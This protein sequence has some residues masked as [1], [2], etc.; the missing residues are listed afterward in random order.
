MANEDDPC[1][2]CMEPLTT[3]DVHTLD[4][5]GHR[6]HPRCIIG[7]LQRGNLSCPTCRHDLHQQEDAIPGMWIRERAKHIRRTMA[8]RPNIPKPLKTLLTRVKR[9]EESERIQRDVLKD[10][11]RTHREVLK[12]YRTLLSKQWKRSDATRTALNLLGLFQSHDF[13]LPALVV[14]RY[15]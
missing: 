9:A 10:F 3:G 6:F 12:Q 8:R 11:K 13:S 15:Y 7:W 4:A 2:V 1:A 5:C 14:N